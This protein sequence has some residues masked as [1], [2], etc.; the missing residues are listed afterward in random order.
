MYEPETNTIKTPFLISL[1]VHTLI[2]ASLPLF[3]YL[4]AKKQFIDLE[5][6]YQ[7][8][9]SGMKAHTNKGGISKELLS[10]QQKSL[11]NAPLPVKAQQKNEPLPLDL[12][13]L[14]KPKETISIPKPKVDPLTEKKQKI[15]LKDLPTE[16]SKDPAYLGYRDILRKKIQD[17]VYYY[18]DQY[19]Y[20][21]N[22]QEGKVFVSFI[23]QSNGALSEV[24]IQDN[25]STPNELLR[26]IAL[27]AIQRAA[28]FDKFP[29]ELTYDERAFNLEIS[30]EIE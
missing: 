3:K 16:M 28:P 11:P 8:P 17:A 10:V 7:S 2:L 9:A 29:A 19:L 22:P 24:L 5:L 12:S 27:I 26:K 6:T 25:K 18:S 15:S 1:I 30:F 23:V 13:K 14:L 4:P 20:F 21:D